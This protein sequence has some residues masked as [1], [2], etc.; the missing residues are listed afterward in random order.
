MALWIMGFGGTVPF[1]LL[2]GGFVAERTSVT[3]VVLI[4]AGVAMMLAAV[5]DV[6]AQVQS[7]ATTGTSATSGSGASDGRR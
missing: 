5:T 6:R 2:A 4:G 1:G 7:A 3:T